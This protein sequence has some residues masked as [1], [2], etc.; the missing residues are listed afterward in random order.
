MPAPPDLTLKLC[1]IIHRASGVQR[2]VPVDT[3]RGRAS[4]YPERLINGLSPEWHAPKTD[5]TIE[6]PQAQDSIKGQLIESRV[7][8]CSSKT[9]LE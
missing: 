1:S 6:A 5:I 4:D 7:P 9:N 2:K 8:L 3:N